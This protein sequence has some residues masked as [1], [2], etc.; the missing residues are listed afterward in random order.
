MGR[1]RILLALAW[2]LLSLA[3]GAAPWA[4]RPAAALQAP[5]DPLQRVRALREA[6]RYNE[7]LEAAGPALGAEP[8][9]RDLRLERGLLLGLLRRYDEALAE[10]DWLLAD[11][12]A[13]VEAFLEHAQI[14]ALQGKHDEAEGEFRFLLALSP[15]LPGAAF[16][17]GDVLVAKGDLAG[18]RAAYLEFVRARPGDARGHARLGH[19]AALAG[20]AAEARARFEEALRLDPANPAARAGLDRLETTAEGVGPPGREGR[21]RFEMGYAH[22]TLTRGQ[23]DWRQGSTLLTFRPWSGTEFSAGGQHVNRFG[24][25]DQSVSLGFS[26]ELFRYF[27]LSG[28][29][30][31]GL[32]GRLLP[33]QSYEGQLA[34]LLKP[35]L[36]PSVSYHFADFHGNVTAGTVSPGLQV[37][38]PWR[39]ALHGRYLRT[40]STDNEPANAFLVELSHET[41]QRFQP[42][43]GYARG[44]LAAGALT[45]EELL[46]ANSQYQS[47]FAG[48]SLRILSWFGVKAD[49]AVQ[50]VKNVY[51]KHTFGLTTFFEF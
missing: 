8:R 4:G 46:S 34:I 26:Q 14:Q 42:Y 37:G 44:G 45:S 1:K 27:T 2:P 20:D 11:N 51:V 49:W 29:F 3:W 40:E 21:F 7:A 13:D 43:V 9:R 36:Q 50:A 15:G 17:L 31:Q 22:E 32:N 23:P 12:P 38:L 6:G 35:W 30:S 25:D 5:S 41:T 19:V 28:R 39:F 10:Y 48:F 24:E 33:K 47:V 18:A 16:G